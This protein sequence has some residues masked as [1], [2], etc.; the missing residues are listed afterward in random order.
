MTDFAHLGVWGI[1][2]EFTVGR[3][4]SASAEIALR[5]AVV[6]THYQDRTSGGTNVPPDDINLPASL[7]QAEAGTTIGAAGIK[8]ATET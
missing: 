2:V 3:G 6:W 4:R 8:V 5:A 1:S 7:Y